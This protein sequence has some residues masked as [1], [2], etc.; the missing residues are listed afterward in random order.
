MR[1]TVRDVASR[2][3]VSAKTV[4]NVVNGT[5][6]VSPETRTRVEQ[7]LTDLDYVPN[8]AA[9]GLRNGRT[10]LIALALPTLRTSYSAEMT[11]HVL[12]AAAKRGLSVQI[13][14][15][16]GGAER[17]RQLVS[18]ARAHLI[19]G[20]V[21]NP[22]LLETSAVQRGVSLPP[23]VL[24]GEV[25]QPLADHV[26][27]D[28]TA[29]SREI[30]TLLIEEGHR[31]IAVLG[32]TESEA[33]RLRVDGYLRA[34]TDAGL[35]REVELEIQV[36]DWTPADGAA[37]VRQFL[38]HHELPDAIFCFTDSMALGVLNALWS[39]GYTVPGDVSVVGYDDIAEAQYAVPPL[40]TVHFDRSTVA[41]SALAL[42]TERIADPQRS[43]R[44]VTI[45]HSIIRR[46]S[47][48]ARQRSLAG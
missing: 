34:L 45:P 40:T 22:E 14:E 9:R 6:P 31:Q 8:L 17:E 11:H 3:G 35:P 38:T 37:A 48:A 20:M 47:T 4:S 28:N 32:K 23:I 24:I 42:L 15:T 39:L 33:S 26:W 12:A 41:E 13:E 29:A 2:A 44:S 46:S 25:D 30:T 7:A 10:G 1:A 18:R 19:D 36:N 16:G 43:I 5:F 21:L 27:I